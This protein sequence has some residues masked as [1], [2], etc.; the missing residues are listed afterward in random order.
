MSC[1]DANYVVFQDIGLHSE[2]GRRTKV[3]FSCGLVIVVL[4]IALFFRAA[5]PNE[6]SFQLGKDV[7]YPIV[8]QNGIT[9]ICIMWWLSIILM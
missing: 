5:N 1:P 6:Y 7:A 8:S 3:Q 9:N 4:I 2:G